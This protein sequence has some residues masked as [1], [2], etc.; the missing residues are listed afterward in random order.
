MKYTASVRD[1]SL[2]KISQGKLIISAQSDNPTD[3]TP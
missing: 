3:V 1:P 2:S